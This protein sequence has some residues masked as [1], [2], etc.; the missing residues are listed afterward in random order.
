MF[1]Y[2][3]AELERIFLFPYHRKRW[4]CVEIM[5][6]T[7]LWTLDAWFHSI[8]S[9]RQRSTIEAVQNT[10]EAQ[11]RIAGPVQPCADMTSFVLP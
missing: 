9:L 1:A 11:R 4:M 10:L 8:L 7:Q 2:P 3:C 5:Q 6:A